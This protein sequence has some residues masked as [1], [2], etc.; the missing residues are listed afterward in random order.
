METFK[1]LTIEVTIKVTAKIEQCLVAK[2][3]STVYISV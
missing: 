1:I 3:K 2:I